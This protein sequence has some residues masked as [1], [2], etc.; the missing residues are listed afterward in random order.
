MRVHLLPQ[1]LP[2]VIANTV[3]ISAAAILAEATLDFL[4][5]GDVAK[6]IVRSVP[7]DAFKS[8][9]AGRGAFWYVLPPGLCIAI[10]VL[11]L[12]FVGHAINEE[13]SPRRLRT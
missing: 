13:L 6:T 4:G 3:L 5:L 10:L 9:A 8:G 2:L 11:S 1:I 12:S 7:V